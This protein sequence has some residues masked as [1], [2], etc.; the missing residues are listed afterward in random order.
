MH[1]KL[2]DM[3][4]KHIVLSAIVLALSVPGC[5]IESNTLVNPPT[6]PLEKVEQQ[7][8][9]QPANSATATPAPAPIIEQYALDRLK[10]M[11]E[12]LAA[13]KSFTYSSNNF[14]E[15]Q[16][17][18][19]GQ[20]ITLFVNTNVALQRPNKFRA[21]VFGDVPSFQLYFDGSNFT[22]FDPEKNNHSVSEPLSTIDDMLAYVA[23]KSHINFPSADFLYS[24]P[25]S[26]MGKNLTHAIVIGP[27]M[28]N[29]LPCEHFAY[30]EPGIN[31][32]I[33]IS[34]GK[35]A[36][37]LRMAMTYKQATNF[38]RYM[39]EYKDWK[40]NPNLKLNIFLF[41]AA[42]NAKRIEF[43]IAQSHKNQNK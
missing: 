34:S 7:P 21:D 17:P 5:A 31:L 38:P 28:V 19:T 33:W 11:S 40:L 4:P 13:A 8:A 26:V 24:N 39:I 29:G 32:E 23:S 14:M 36:L 6:Q 1:K 16:S 41:K 10:Q 18:V 2:I 43:D 35:K 37:P 3:M 15:V 30:M 12:T 42:N 27:T 22:A 20:F 9:T 25:Y